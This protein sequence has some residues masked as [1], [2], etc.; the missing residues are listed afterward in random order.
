[1][2]TH[3]LE[4]LDFARIRE[5]LAGYA[6]TGLGRSLVEHIQPNTRADLVRR[7]L[8]QV[9]ELQRQIEE[10]GTPPFGGISDVREILQRCGPPLRVTVDEMAQIAGTLEGTHAV[11]DYLRDQP[12]DRPELQH[13]A[14]RVGDFRSIAER[15]RRVIDERGQVRDDASPKL[16][17]IRAEIDAAGQQIRQT[18][19]H[20][21]R[22]PETRRMLQY[23]NHTFH[24]DR[25]VLPLKT[26]YRG[27]LPGIVHRASDSGATLYVEP[28]AIVEL[29]N[30]IS[31]LRSEEQEEIGRLLWDLTHE[32]HL[33]EKEIRKTLETL[34]VLD[35]IAAKVRFA[36]DYDLHCPEVCPE[37][38]LNVRN[39]RHPL[40]LE[41]AR[42]KRDSG[43]SPT[44]IVPIDYRIGD[45]FQLLII[46]GPNTGGKTVALKTIGLLSLMVQAGL[47]IPA[48]RGSQ[49]GLFSE[50]LIDVGDEQSMQQSLSTFSG[51]LTRILTILKHAGPRVL[52]LIDELGAGTDPDEGAALGRAILDE[53]RRLDCRAV[54]TTHLGALKSYALM[55][56]RAE[57]A[58]VE[59][60]STTLRPTFHLRIGEPG[61]SNAIAV[62]EHLGMP[63]RLIDAARRNLSWKARALHAALE[64]TR[65]VKR[66]AEHACRAAED[67]RQAASQAET[68]AQHAR[69]RFERDQADF[70]TWLQRVVHL[71]PGDPV[72]VRDF[73]RDGKIVRLRLDQQRAE[74]DVGAFCVEVPLADLLPPET[75]PPPPRPPRPQVVAPRPDG[76]RPRRGD[77][78]PSAPPRA[79]I[80]PEK[81][82][83][84]HDTAPKP[85]PA[86]P[87]LTPEQAAALK[88]LDAI[89]VNRF[90]REGQVVRV[91]PAKNLAIVSVGML[92]MEVPF[93]GLAV[94]PSPDR[95][96]P[97]RVPA[98]RP[99]E[100]HAATP[101]E[102][103]S[104]SLAECVIPPIAP[105]VLSAPPPDA[106][107]AS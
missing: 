60:D 38:K 47:P 13:L 91:N 77:G 95:P 42:R 28:A 25:L 10:R 86:L 40:L 1:M 63:R 31:N 19:D 61:E 76:R 62:A 4:C 36:R 20:L 34:A 18:L 87:P 69:A 103:T 27:R 11:A 23:S 45:D 17:T 52:I 33:N 24:G 6:L 7:W 100:S 26:E 75:P 3:T 72:R 43:D 37:G 14:G 98:P 84:A 58:C 70:H 89:Y 107:S 57:N 106:P 88:P 29:N 96:R 101:V 105:E 35:L 65:Q 46:T 56:E 97:P 83:E 39:A 79:A 64:G 12:A 102:A 22:E 32:I 81:A 30:R 48:A 51:H 16:Q 94:P 90:H 5:L 9:Q 82:R 44:E 104:A 74:V 50:L 15:I 73:D 54:V 53:L 92:E 71:R 78:R 80:P 2:D 85:R 68:E 41:L 21:L 8:T 66:Q 55:N 99:A 93:S 49:V 67:A 59:F